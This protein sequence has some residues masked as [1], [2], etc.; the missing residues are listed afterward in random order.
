VTIAARAGT[1]WCVPVL[2]P[3]VLLAAGL[4]F[5]LGLALNAFGLAGHDARRVP[6]AR[7]GGWV[8]VVVCGL[9]LLFTIL[10]AGLR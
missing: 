2:L 10:T 3:I 5:G 4:A 9:G 8:I 7:R 1:I 6:E